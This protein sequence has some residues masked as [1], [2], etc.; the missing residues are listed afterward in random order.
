MTLYHYISARHAQAGIVYEDASHHVGVIK[1]ASQGISSTISGACA[2]RHDLTTFCEGRMAKGFRSAAPVLPSPARLKW[3]IVAVVRAR[4]PGVTSAKG[5]PEAGATSAPYFQRLGMKR[6]A[7][8]AT[9]GASPNRLLR[10]LAAV[11]L[12]VRAIQPVAHVGGPAIDHHAGHGHLVSVAAA[13]THHPEKHGDRDPDHQGCHFCRL[14]DI[15]LPP[16]SVAFVRPTAPIVVAWQE[17]TQQSASARHFLV[18]LQ[19][20]A[21][22]QLA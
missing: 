17:T 14:D 6:T 11:L 3:H 22:P 19:P 10:V 13:D 16:P 5:K 9:K 1:A 15:A 21:P 7:A 18:C 20:R 8:C 4:R 2:G 12:L